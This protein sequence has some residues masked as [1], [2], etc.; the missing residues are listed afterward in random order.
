MF[1]LEPIGEQQLSIA[2]F[3]L[4]KDSSQNY[5][6]VEVSMKLNHSF[7]L[8]ISLYVVPAIC[9]PLVSQ[10][11]S[12][13]VSEYLHLR[14][15]QLADDSDGTSNLE[16]RYTCGVRPLLGVSY[17]MSDQGCLWPCCHSNQT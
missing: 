9:E 13:C 5:P 4:T 2:T 8:C 7:L 10:P 14:A 16:D 3:G 6:V 12:V 17:G 1:A 11:V 15:L